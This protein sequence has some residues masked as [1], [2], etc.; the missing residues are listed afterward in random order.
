MEP[1]SNAYKTSIV[2]GVSSDDIQFRKKTPWLL[3]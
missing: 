1:W 2:A 3:K